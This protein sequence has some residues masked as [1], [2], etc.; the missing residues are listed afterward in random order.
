MIVTNG[1]VLNI[2]ADLDEATVL[3][4]QAAA[5]L[6]QTTAALDEARRQLALTRRQRDAAGDPDLILQ[7]RRK[8]SMAID[9]LDGA[10]FALARLAANDLA[11]RGVS[12]G[13]A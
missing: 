8:L 6:P 2:R 13:A 4:R 7:T 3:M 10:S 12:G 5:E 9:E 11:Q 1:R